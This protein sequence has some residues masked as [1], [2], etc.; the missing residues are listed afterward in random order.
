[1][2]TLTGTGWGDVVSRLAAFQE[3]SRGD[4]NYLVEEGDI[5]LILSRSGGW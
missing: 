5:N 4:W 3:E 1:V 2:C